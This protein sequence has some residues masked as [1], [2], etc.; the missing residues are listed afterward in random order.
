MVNCC[1]LRAGNFGPKD[2]IDYCFHVVL[3]KERSHRAWIRSSAVSA[4]GVRLQRA[5]A[6][7][8]AS[9]CSP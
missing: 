3:G 4:R 1:A 7:E 9:S 5:V 8:I 2:A 6:F